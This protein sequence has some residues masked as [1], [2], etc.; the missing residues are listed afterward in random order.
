MATTMTVK[1]QV[2]IP[3]EVRDAVGIQPGDKVEVRA[4][5]A[6]TVIIEKPNAQDDYDRRLQ[7]VADM[8]LIPDGLTTDE[9]MKMTRGDPAEDPPLKQK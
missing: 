3:K 6:G 7:R 5:G 8:R 2:T 9:I 1:G 4:T